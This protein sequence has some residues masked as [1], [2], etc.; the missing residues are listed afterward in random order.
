MLD[1]AVA[2]SI[3]SGHLKMFREKQLSLGQLATICRMVSLT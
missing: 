2:G 3:Y 1:F